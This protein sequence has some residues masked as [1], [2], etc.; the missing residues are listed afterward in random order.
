MVGN[1]GNVFDDENGDGTVDE[2][3][4][5]IGYVTIKGKS[6]RGTESRR[7]YSLGNRNISPRDY[8]ITIVRQGGGES[9]D[10]GNAEIPYIQIFGL[11]QN[12]DGSVDPEFIDFDRGLLTFPDLRPFVIDDSCKSLLSI[13]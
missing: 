3:G 5:E 11:D 6:L 4:E 8:R 2:E 1:P 10:I 7:V 12:G 9:F 13:S